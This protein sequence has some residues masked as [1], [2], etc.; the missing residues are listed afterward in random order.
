MTREKSLP[1]RCLKLVPHATAVPSVPVEKLQVY[2][3][4]SFVVVPPRSASVLP[5]DWGRPTGQRSH[6]ETCVHD[7]LQASRAAQVG[8]LLVSIDNV[9]ESMRLS[10]AGSHLRPHVTEDPYLATSLPRT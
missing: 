10:L 5:G 6:R 7:A 4:R 1:M 3:V 8:A 2:T 9:G